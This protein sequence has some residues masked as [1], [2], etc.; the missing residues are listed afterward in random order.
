MR[1]PASTQK[2]VEREQARHGLLHGNTG[3]VT[4]LCVGLGFWEF[5]RRVVHINCVSHATTPSISNMSRTKQAARRK[6]AERSD[7]KAAAG[8]S[9][10]SK[11]QRTNSKPSAQEPV[12]KS[13]AKD[14]IERLLGGL[15]FER[16]LDEYFEKK[17]LLVKA[18][19]SGSTVSCNSHLPL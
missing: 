2:R 14:V 5:E 6:K 9:N 18:K 15:S 3:S 13:S 19:T 11:K 7:T 16:F 17:P 12:A 1:L 8:A 10:A 4:Q